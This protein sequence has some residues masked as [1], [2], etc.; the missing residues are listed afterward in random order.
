MPS[1]LQQAGSQPQKQPKYVPIFEDRMFTGL[2]TQR[3]VLHDP[4]DIYT[5]KFYGGR[6]DA[7]WMGSN[8]ELT[9]R[10]T[11]QR[12]PGMTP[13]STTTY[14][15]PP[16]DAYSFQLSDGTLRVIID[17]QATSALVLTGAADASGGTTVYTG[18][19]T[20]GGGNNYQGYTFVVTGFDNFSNNGTYFCTASTATTLT[21]AN[22]SGAAD[23]SAGAAVSPGAV[24]WDQQNGTKTLLYSKTAGAGQTHFQGVNGILYAGDGVDTWKYTPLNTNLNPQTINVVNPAGVSVWNWGIAKPGIQ[25]NV[26]IVASGS[27]SSHWQANTIFSTMGLT[28]DS[29]NNIWQLISVDSNPNIPNAPDAIFGTAGD[30]SPDWQQG[31]NQSTVEGSGTPI[32]WI[33]AG[34]V[35]EWTAGA[36]WGDAGFANP[37]APVCCYDSHSNAF[38]LNFNG[39][40]AP[41]KSGS[42]SPAFTANPGWNFT[43]QHG[44]GPS[45]FNKP[46]W[47]YFCSAKTG[48]A[49]AQPWKSGHTYLKWISGAAGQAPNVESANTV[50]EPYI[51]PP[52]FN[53]ASVPAPQPVFL[54]YP[55]NA[56]TSGS[57]YAP[58]PNPAT[59]TTYA[60]PTY[61]YGN[62]IVAD[63]QLSWVCLGS[64]TRQINHA[65][66]PWSV[67]GAAFGCF[68]DPNGNMQVCVKATGSGLSSSTATASITW[69]VGYSAPTTDGDLTWVNVGPPTAWAAGTSTSGIWHLPLTGFAPPQPSQKYGGSTIDGTS[70]ST[71]QTVISSGKSGSGAEPTWALPTDSNPDTTDNGI[72][73]FAESLVN[74][75]SLAWTK[76]Y[77]YAYSYKARAVDDFYSPL[78][79]GGG[80]TGVEQIPPGWPGPLGPPTGSA[81]EAV[82]TAS[83]A[84]VFVGTNAGAVNTISGPYSPDP[85][86]DTIIIWRSADGGGSGQMFE[87]T[88]IP[89]NYLLAVANWVP[90]NPGWSYQDYQPDTAASTE[91]PGLNYLIP[92]PID[93]VND[94][95]ASTFLPMAYNFERIWGADKENA[96]FSGGPDTQVGNPN[97]AFAPADYLPFLA[98]V[99]RLVKT[100]QGLV[101]FLTDSIEVIAGGPQTN[102][103][104][105]VTWAP[106]IG[107]L[108]YNMLD[109]FAGEIYFFSADNQ[110]RIMTPSLNIANAGFAIGDQ[111]ANAPS[112]GVS[113]ASW[114]PTQG[115]VA[116]HQN[117]TDNAIFLAD[118]NTG[119]YRLNPRQAGAT[120]NPE[121]VWSPF[122]TI[123]G[124]NGCQMVKSVET[125]PGIKKLLVGSNVPAQEI[126]QR[127]LT[128]FSDNGR[129]YDAYFIMGSIMLAHPGELALLKFIEMDFSGVQYKPTVSYL[130]NEISGTFTPFTHDPIPDPPSLYGTTTH[131]TTYSPNRYYF[132]GNASLARC[133][134]MQIK[135]DF[136]GGSTPLSA[137]VTEVNIT[138]NVLTLT[139]D[140]VTGFASGQTVTLSGFT[141]AS[142][143]F[144]N[145]ANIVLTGV[146]GSTITANY[147]HA[148]YDS[149]VILD[150]NTT[151]SGGSSSSWTVT[152]TTTQNND[153]A[154]LFQASTVASVAGYTDVPNGTSGAGILNAYAVVPSGA[155]SALVTASGSPTY[156]WQLVCLASNGAPTF[157]TAKSTG[158]STP[159][160]TITTTGVSVVAGDAI[161]VSG[162]GLGRMG[163]VG[164]TCA[165]T[166]GNVYVNLGY[167]A[168][169]GRGLITFICYSAVSTGSV[170]ITATA[171]GGSAFDNGSI[172]C[173]SV[174]GISAPPPTDIG[175]ATTFINS[176]STSGDEVFNTTIFG[177][178]MIET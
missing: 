74:A 172:Y 103:F 6:P 152:G 171:A 22:T 161:I 19:I 151:G 101:T 12:R 14:P 111:L 68:E 116:S 77:A 132:L 105:S 137:N 60:A 122:A 16:N 150:N 134:H 153:L 90:G 175:V 82:S 160:S 147:T 69:A 118:G 164:A 131:P 17:T 38:Y 170:D 148:D 64:K 107:L 50:F 63:G 167:S 15:T 157:G 72:T 70:N 47:F 163:G 93:D 59:D 27:A 79:L 133:R 89:N 99:I 32:T 121:P 138:S 11:L 168:G 67:Q 34:Q 154:L 85:Q 18:T 136:G 176:G 53:P 97:E 35:M 84:F 40:G 140:D 1:V 98:P 102:S 49:L 31:L 26:N 128:V 158:V 33:N 24:Y 9:N 76:G 78:P 86:V 115:Y 146:V 141:L 178:I 177:R 159:H 13:F 42:V 104:F 95:P 46:H 62:T 43:E 75:N 30:G 4:S 149:S 39:S 127:D 55:N 124:V 58:F 66:A 135:V 173:Y 23:T 92:A 57:A 123:S 125:A 109:V 139:L 91:E 61:G 80:G 129:A 156:L 142:A 51:M 7:L 120:Q 162:I 48:A 20:G 2:F 94:P 166:A 119:W 130:L 144:L 37:V 110:F 8:V 96:D 169:G 155:Q 87:L 165:D 54:Q 112:S 106:G 56:G 117:G 25:P 73:W 108:S 114:D 100:P 174:G 36:V 81:T 126:L 65:Y 41:S 71:V 44:A 3:N 10:L 88:E 45:G 83:P 113:D 145:G 52:N 5:A 29:Y 21:L 28:V 143:L